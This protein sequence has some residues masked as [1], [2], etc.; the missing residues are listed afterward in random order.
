MEKSVNE[1]RNICIVGVGL[2]PFGRHPGRMALELGIVAAKEALQDAGIGWEEIQLAYGT[3]LEA[4]LD[5]GVAYLGQ[6]GIP[7]INVR[8]GCASAGSALFAAATAIEAGRCETAIVIGADN[9]ERGA[10]RSD[11]RVWGIPAWL[12][13]SGFSVAPQFFAMKTQRYF[14]EHG[15]SPET[16]IRVAERAFRNGS[17]TP[18]AWRREALSFETIAASPMMCD[19]LRQFMLTNPCGGGG[20]VILCRADI[21]HRYTDQPIR[22]EAVAIRTRGV[23]T[24]EVGA[25]SIA[26]V[27]KP[28]PT[29]TASRQAFE[30]AGMGPKDMDVIQLQD[31]DSGTEIIHYEECGFCEAG[32]QAHLVASGA[33]EIGGRLPINTD[34]GLLAN[35]EPVGASG[36]RQVYEITQQLRGRAGQRQVPGNPRTGFTHVYGGPGVSAVTILS[37]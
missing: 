35:G 6:T 27:L 25:P 20:A 13:A 3:S 31:T 16:A 9:H 7:F 24:F 18:H 28:G 11:P 2:C 30:M 10:F 36:L 23:D 21:A 33:T 29:V 26:N 22:L 19:P 8:N 17:I 37:R 4:V 12:S 15:I 32:E 1:L 5:T 14:H 34:G